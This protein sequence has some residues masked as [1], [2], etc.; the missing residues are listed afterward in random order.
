M[1]VT[2]SKAGSD[3]LIRTS[4]VARGLSEKFRD[5]PISI[6]IWLSRANDWVRNWP[7][8]TR[9]SVNSTLES[10]SS[11]LFLFAMKAQL[12]EKR[13]EGGFCF[14]DGVIFADHFEEPRLVPSGINRGYQP[15]FVAVV[16]QWIAADKV[17]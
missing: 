3:V 6:G 12:L 8:S 1:L 14:F 13:N 9:M 2:S 4:S 7:N 16:D 10:R 15:F 11:P 17:D 5:W